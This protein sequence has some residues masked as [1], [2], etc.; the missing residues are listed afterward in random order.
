MVLQGWCLNKIDAITFEGTGVYEKWVNG[1]GLYEIVSPNI[2]DLK[3]KIKIYEGQDLSGKLL[4]Q[5]EV[6]LNKEVDFQ[7]N[8]HYTYVKFLSAI[9]MRPCIKYT[10][11]IQPNMECV[12]YFGANGAKDTKDFKFYDTVFEDK[13][14]NNSTNTNS[15]LFPVFYYE[16]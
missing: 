4:Y 1:I 3:I 11:S 16:Q 7:G 15:G 13:G 14:E 6:A 8:L 10:I 2:E 9:K 5:Q 12:S